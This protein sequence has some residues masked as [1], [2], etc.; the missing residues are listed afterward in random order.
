M[1]SEF[2]VAGKR[3]SRD[4]TAKKLES[5]ATGL[6][7]HCLQGSELGAQVKDP[8]NGGDSTGRCAHSWRA[9]G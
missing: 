1:Q 8:P 7:P 2:R 3:L 6:G 9:G 5:V 4:V